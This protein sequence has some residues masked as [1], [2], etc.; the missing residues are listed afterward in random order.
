MYN[1]HARITEGYPRLALNLHLLRLFCA[2]A[3]ERSF[4]RAARTL[5]VSQPAVSKG[6]RALERQLDTAL[7]ERQGKAARAPQLTAAGSALLE[8]ARAIFALEQAAAEDLRARRESRRGRVSL[9]ASTTVA[10][11]W[12][13]SRVARFAQEC[14]GIELG[15]RV[16]NTQSIAQALLDCAIDLALVEGAVRH[17]RIRSRVWREEELVMVAGRGRS[18]RSG[19]GS[20]WAR[21]LARVPW[22]I[23]EQGSGTREVGERLMQAHGLEPA[24]CIEYG[25]NEGIARAAAAGLGVALLPRCVARDLLELGEL[26]A[27]TLPRTALS[28]RPLYLLELTDRPASSAACRLRERLLSEAARA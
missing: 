13:P 20:D 21:A 19:R 7:F 23:R 11:Y 9:G 18:P 8:H 5:C 28:S 25:S 24:R 17:P 27:I 22:L 14:P 15:I 4:S 16:G 3:T 1:S 10:G 6:V 26:E 12:L 2:V